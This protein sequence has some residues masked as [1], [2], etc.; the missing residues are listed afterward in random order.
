MSNNIR[1][2]YSIYPLIIKGNE[3]FERK[4]YYFKDHDNSGNFE[5]KAL[6]YCGELKDFFRLQCAED[7]ISFVNLL[8]SKQGEYL[9]K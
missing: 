3:E 4:Y 8:N 5:G 2:R 1:P 9:S 6:Y 7:A